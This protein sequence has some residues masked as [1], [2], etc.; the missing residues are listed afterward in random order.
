M[1]AIIT[2]SSGFIGKALIEHL[3]GSIINIID[4]IDKRNG[5]DVLDLDVDDYG[6]VDL[7]I[8]L[9]AQT[10][11]FNKNLNAIM[12][13][14][15]FAFKKVVDFSNYKGAKLIYASSSCSVNITSLYGISKQFNEEYAKIYANNATGIRFHNV[16]SKNPREGTL[17]YNLITQERPIIFNNGNN[18]RHFT[19]IDD[20]LDGIIY[21]IDSNRKVLNIRNPEE[22]TVAEFIEEVGKYFDMSKVVFTDKEK[23]YDKHQ[24]LVD[25]S[26]YAVDLKYKSIKDGLMQEFLK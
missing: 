1:N 9:A 19:H 21:A 10:S 26:I 13:D 6:A 11:V 12:R 14:N 23:E 22:N 5:K 4:L 7:I 16:Y 8:H 2:G 24:Q 25:E 15:I 3:N 17:L 20:I 18:K